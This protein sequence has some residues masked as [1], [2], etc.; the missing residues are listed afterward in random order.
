MENLIVFLNSSEENDKKKIGEVQQLIIETLET[1]KTTWVQAW[2]T[3]QKMF[4]VTQKIIS[5]QIFF[6][7][8]KVELL[9]YTM[10]NMKKN[11]LL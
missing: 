11:L 2:L 7:A 10:I 3:R 4:L 5:R 8:L 9:F 6:D 1:Q